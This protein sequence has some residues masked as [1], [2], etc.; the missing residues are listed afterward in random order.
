MSRVD[1]NPA[2]GWQGDRRPSSTP[3]GAEIAGGCPVRSRLADHGHSGQKR[4]QT[5]T[6]TAGRSAY[7]PLTLMKRGGAQWT[8]SLLDRLPRAL[9]AFAHEPAVTEEALLEA[10]SCCRAQSSLVVSVVS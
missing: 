7:S 4:H 8:S 2:P 1:S 10:F 9:R 5:F 3:D 6:E